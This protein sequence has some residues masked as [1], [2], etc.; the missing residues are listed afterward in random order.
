MLSSRTWWIN[1]DSD[2][3]EYYAVTHNDIQMTVMDIESHLHFRNLKKII[4]EHNS[5]FANIN[6]HIFN[7]V[8]SL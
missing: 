1:H 2:S 5:T 8:G 6:M 4:K 3:M 7:V